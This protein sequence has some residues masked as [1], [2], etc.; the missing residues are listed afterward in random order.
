[1]VELLKISA[2]SGDPPVLQVDGEI[3]MSTAEQLR[4]A[5]ENALAADPTVVVDMAGV[6]FCDAAGLRVLL[7]A[8]ASLN[9]TGPLTLLNAARVKRL[10]EIVGMRD[11]SCIALHDES[12]PRD[13]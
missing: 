4:I 12:A 5:L 3:D 8:A 13:R 1:V 2:L 7:Q 6:T 11:V 9:G 10:L